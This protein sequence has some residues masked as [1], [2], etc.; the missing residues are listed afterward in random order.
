MSRPD[1]IERTIENL[2]AENVKAFLALEAQHDE[3]HEVV[4]DY[5]KQ[6]T[7]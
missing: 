5:R 4:R 6:P 2:P 3:W 7:T 1:H